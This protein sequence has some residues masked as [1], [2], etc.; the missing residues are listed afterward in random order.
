MK[1]RREH[2]YITTKSEK[3]LYKEVVFETS[4]KQ[5]NLKSVSLMKKQKPLRIRNFDEAYAE[6][7][8]NAK[9]PR[10]PQFN[11]PVAN[12]HEQYTDPFKYLDKPT[13]SQEYNFHNQELLYLKNMSMK[14]MFLTETFIREFNSRQLSLELVPV[15]FGDY[16]YYRNIINMA[17]NFTIYR[18]PAS[19]IAEKDRAKIPTKDLDINEQVVFRLKDLTPFYD[20]YALR[21]QAI[22]E[23]VEKMSDL[24]VV[25]TH[26]P[27]HWFSTNKAGNYAAVVFD[28]HQDGKNYEVI[29]KDMVL[30]KIMPM[31]IR[32]SNGD[33]AF[34]QLNGFYY[35]LRDSNG[36]GK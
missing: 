23:F 20:N 12:M 33:L 22:K 17:D 21:N 7:M 10:H 16:M 19:K 6:G 34:D 18:Y 11:D 3:V 30:G 29:V 36:R 9:L 14:H 5:T 32:N 2:K 26:D 24:S 1:Y 8:Q 15:Q 28:L 25:Q 4:N 31:I 35:V 27:I 13:E